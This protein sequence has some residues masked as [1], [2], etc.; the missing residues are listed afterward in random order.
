[1]CEEFARAGVSVE[2][3]VPTRKN[4][5]KEDLFSF[6]NLEKNF[7]VKYIKCA[8]A[9]TLVK[10]L[11]SLSFYL[12]SIWYL[13]KLSFQNIGHD[14]FIIT[15]NAEI[16]WLFGRRN[17][18]VVFDAH[19][20]PESKIRL[21]KRFIK[22]IYK[23]VCNSN[24]TARVYSQNGWQNSLVAPNGVDINHFKI[25]SSSDELR[26]KLG[27]PKIKKIIMYIGH[28]YK[29]KGVEIIFKTAE[30]LRE[31]KDFYF[32]VIGGTDKDVI[33]YKKQIEE[34]G[35][36][37]VSLLGHKKS[38]IIPE[39]LL[40]ADI[41]ILPNIASTLESERYTSPIKMFEYMASGHPIIASDLPSIREVL[42]EEIAV[43]FTAGEAKELANKIL[44]LDKN[45]DL[46]EKIAR[47]ARQK[48]E[49]FTWDKRAQ[50]I[51][52]FIES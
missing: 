16:A 2:L 21:F 5:I 36:T 52:K 7:T 6:Y 23:L 28:L 3:W 47:N 34:T 40:A 46:G 10:Y 35:L 27:L 51:I 41:L 29:W 14:A 9:L 4:L 25:K 18:K 8:D 17:Y 44:M 20:W 38:K 42:N 33:Y 43:F 26:E 32:V 11:G 49:G 13:F 15:R 1:M 22:R 30:L 50:K 19:N 24:G 31:R 48:A 45:I 39:Y 37:A 12:Q